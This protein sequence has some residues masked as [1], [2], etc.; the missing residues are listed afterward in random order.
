VHVVTHRTE[1]QPDPATG[2][3][4]VDDLDRAMRMAREAAGGR[5]VAI[6]GGADIIRQA[7]AAGYVDVLAI[8]TAP[9]V[10]GGGKRLFAG[11]EQ[12]VELEPLAVHQSRWATHVTYAVR[13]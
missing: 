10:L 9:V 5:D 2:F 13:R 3:V 8:S 11:F 4:F 7:L 6:G 12:D 1:D